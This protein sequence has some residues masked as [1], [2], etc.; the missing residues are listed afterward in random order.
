MIEKEIFGHYEDQ[1]VWR[2]TLSN[3][4]GMQVKI[5]NY[6]ATVTS[7]SIPDKTGG[8]VELACGFDSFASYFTEE[9]TDNAPYF[10]STVGRYSSRI[11]DGKFS[12]NGKQFQLATNDGS[13]HLHGGIKGFDKRVWEERK[14]DSENNLLVLSLLSKDGEEGYPGNVKVEVSYQLTDQRELV[15]SY[16]ALPDQDTPLG[17]TN[18]TYFN[19]SG[20]KEDLRNHLIAIDTASFLVPDVTNVPVGESA[21]VNDLPFDVTSGVSMAK[22]W[23]S[24]PNG[25]EHYF[26]FDS[27]QS[28]VYRAAISHSS[29]GR[30]LKVATTEPGMLF[31]T[32]MYTSDKLER[33]NGDRFGKFRAFCCETHP[34]PNGPN[35]SE[36]N[37]AIA[38]AGETYNSQTIFKLDW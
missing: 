6:G 21:L 3:K 11:K 29:S 33:E 36:A 23:Q 9:Y 32:G 22:V 2:Y 5:M 8:R 31:Y 26:T 17:L 1:E 37:G 24:L 30:T 34:Y 19:L 10:G 38:P 25:F 12:I 18:H 27:S 35:L 16:M 15:I 4:E 13:N 20:F 28:P 7:V 14:V